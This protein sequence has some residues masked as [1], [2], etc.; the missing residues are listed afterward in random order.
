MSL[1]HCVTGDLSEAIFAVE[2]IRRGYTVY[3]PSVGHSHPADAIIVK[4]PCRPISVQLKTATV[5]KNRNR[6][7]SV[8]VCRGKGSGKVSYQLGDFDILAAWLPDIQQFVFWHFEEIATRK[9]INYSPLRHRA[10][11]NWEVFAPCDISPLADIITV[12]P[13]S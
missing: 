3:T 4:P 7:Y 13:C 8:M 1:S 11:G 9:K 12:Q 2:G 10:P 6:S 5:V